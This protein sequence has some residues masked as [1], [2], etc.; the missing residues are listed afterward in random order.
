M[1][2][3]QQR[4]SR[5]TGATIQVLDNREQQHFT[6]DDDVPEKW[7]TVCVDHGFTCSHQT[8]QLAV[9][10]ASEPQMWCDECRCIWVNKQRPIAEP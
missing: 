1:P 10:W 6:W 4:K 7:W 9:A 2:M 3:V 5:R 8:R